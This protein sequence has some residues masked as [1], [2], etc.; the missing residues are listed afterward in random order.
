MHTRVTSQAETTTRRMV[1][2]RLRAQRLRV[3]RIRRTVLT[4][5][6][7]V[8]AALWMAIYVQLATG[9]D[10]ALAGVTH[11]NPT[12]AA[13]TTTASKAQIAKPHRAKVARKPKRAAAPSTAPSTGAG[14]GSAAAT[15]SGNASSGSRQT[16]TA[17]APVTTRQS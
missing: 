2:E 6:A 3:R 9:H 13:S 16:A 12:T 8:F 17:P 14:A 4:C 7:A 10:P 5:G 1:R 15:G 11:R